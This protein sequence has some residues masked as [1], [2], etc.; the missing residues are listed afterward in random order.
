MRQLA[1]AGI[2][3]QSWQQEASDRDRDS[4]HLSM[5]KA[6]CEFETE[7]HKAAKEKRRKQKERAA[8]LPSS[9]QT[10]ACPKCGRGCA[11]RI[12]LYSHQRAFLDQLACKNWPSIFPSILVCE[13][14]AII[15][16]SASFVNVCLSSSVTFSII[17][18]LA[19][20]F[21]S[22][23]NTL[24]FSPLPP[25]TWPEYAQALHCAAQEVLFLIWSRFY[26]WDTI[27]LDSHR[28][29]SENIDPPA[30]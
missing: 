1:Q 3:H 21:L 14:W 13:E 26:F 2:S 27:D 5:R 23:E 28:A 20:I 10:F 4:W 16:L 17:F 15:I 9:S 22:S 19:L 25:S 8:S 11:S 18:E 29:Y 30:R 7:T 24:H 12:G 6:S